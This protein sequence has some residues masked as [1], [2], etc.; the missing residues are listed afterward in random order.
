M[1]VLTLRH[2]IMSIRKAMKNNTLQGFQDG[3][4]GMA[5]ANISVMPNGKVVYCAVGC[6]LDHESLQKASDTMLTLGS[7][8][9]L[10]DAKIISVS[11]DEIHQI[12]AIQCQHDQI[13]NNPE[14]REGS[15]KSFLAMIDCLEEALQEQ[16]ILL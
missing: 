4:K 14:N 3:A 6:A 7:V 1:Q 11:S 13:I 15:K 9:A 2:V 16:P 12:H 8:I 10:A 5:C